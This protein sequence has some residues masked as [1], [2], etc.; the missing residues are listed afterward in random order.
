MTAT[1][2]LSSWIET[3]SGPS[4]GMVMTGRGPYRRVVEACAKLPCKAALMDGEIIIQDENG[5][6][7]FDALRS[8]INHKAAIQQRG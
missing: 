7:D 8:A 4:A 2:P 5:T 6:S 3:G 1:A